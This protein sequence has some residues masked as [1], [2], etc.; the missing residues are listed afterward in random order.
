[1]INAHALDLIHL[2]LVVK[3]IYIVSY[4]LEVCHK[5]I[6]NISPQGKNFKNKI[7]HMSEFIL[8]T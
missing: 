4:F 2:A 7:K 6:W 3:N 8:N 1:M 5:A